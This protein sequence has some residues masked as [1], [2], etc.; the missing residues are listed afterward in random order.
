MVLFFI[1]SPI[2]LA[3]ISQAEEPAAVSGYRMPPPAIAALADAPP[4]PAASLSPTREWLLLLERPGLL[5]ITELAQPELRL[6]G[7]RFNPRT[8]GPSRAPYFTRLVLRRIADGEERPVVGLP[9]DPRIRY[10][11]W[12][13]DGSRVAFTLTTPTGVELWVAEVSTARARRLATVLLN[14]IYGTPYQWLPDSRGLLC[15]L[16][17]ADRG[18]P[19]AAPEAPIGPVIQENTGEKAPARTY[20]DLLKNAH[21]EALF[22]H[23]VTAQPVRVTLQGRVIP[24]GPAGL[25]RRAEPSPDGRYFL[26]EVVHRPFSY[27]VP[28]SRFPYRVEVRDREGRVVC[29]VADLPLAEQ[30]PIAFDAVPAGPRAFGWRA[31]APATLSW[32][33]AQDGGDPHLAAEVRDR[34]F[35]LPAPFEGRP[36]PLAPLGLRFAGI[37]WGRDD[38]ALVSETWWRTRRERTWIVAPGR[39]EAPPVLLWD[40]SF[41]DRYGDPGSPLMRP[42]PAGTRVLFIGPDERTLY[43]VGDGASP[44]GDRPFLDLL[45]LAT[46]ATRRLFRSEALYYERPLDLLD[47]EKGLLLTSRE[48]ASEPPNYFVRNWIGGGLRQLTRFPHPAPQLAEARK[49]LIRYRRDDGVE[50]TATL[51]LPPGYSSSDGPLPTLFWAY[52]RE[53]RSADAAGQVRD[54]PH[55]FARLHWGSP[56]FW[57]AMGYAVLDN[58]AMP[59][60]G[61]GEREPNDT[62][63][64]QLVA[65]ARAAVEELVRRGVADRDRI[66]IGGHSYGAFMTANLLAH[67][68]LFRA[69]IARSGAYNRTLTPFGFQNERRTLWE[70][71]E[72]YIRVSPFMY[73]HKINEPLLLIHGEADNNP[74][75]FPMQSERMYQ[76]I[77]GNGGTVR[78][79]MLPLESHGYEARESIEHALYEMVAWFDRFVKNAPPR[80][81]RDEAAR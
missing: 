7:L 67:S 75:T 37:R 2:L 36:I 1:V 44:E 66:A 63:V 16:V 45:D 60:V 64:E 42:T 56:L 73:A 70:A 12:S 49:E 53:F 48:S 54:S 39:P 59:I 10:V 80:R 31:D 65:S 74:G 29:V 33:E 50:L 27:L 69:G 30:V 58:P 20:Q 34:L 46:R 81:T 17:P 14:A 9:D 43:L 51:Y 41:E 15:R 71:P 72:L 21:D 52:P 40:R 13:P 62:Y 23:Y 11:A 77:R 6:A 78:F 79:V 28:A 55:R 57:L 76:A 8:Y 22:E 47:P 3:G 68:D 35:L 24:L 4:T 18:E 26:C 25:I 19:P 38:L 5:P 32:T 61:E